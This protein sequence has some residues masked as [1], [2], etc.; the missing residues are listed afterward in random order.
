MH[1]RCI[2]ILANPTGVGEEACDTT[3]LSRVLSNLA[4]LSPKKEHVVICCT[5]MPGYIATTGSCVNRSALG[6]TE[7]K[8]RN[9]NLGENSS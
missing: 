1:H 9:R 8:S 6:R 7:Q 4:S 3:T 5:V 2:F